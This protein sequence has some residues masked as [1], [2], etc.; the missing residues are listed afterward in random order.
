MRAMLTMRV[1][2]YWGKLPKEVEPPSLELL[3]NW[4]DTE[5]SIWTCSDQGLHV[6]IYW[7]SLLT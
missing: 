5:L 7:R 3:K 2:I 1:I 6:D 4:L